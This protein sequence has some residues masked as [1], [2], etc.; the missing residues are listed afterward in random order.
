MNHSHPDLLFRQLFDEASCTFTYL[1]ADRKTGEAILI[2]TVREKVDRELKLLG[3]LNLKLVYLLETHI[4]ADHITGASLLRDK[5]GAKTVVG[6]GSN[7]ECANFSLKDGE[8]LNFGQFNLKALATPGHTHACTSFVI[9]N[10]VFTG[11]ALLIRGTGRTDFQQGS[12]QMLFHSIRE[13]LFKLPPETHVYPAHDYNGRT[14]S[15]I[16]EEQAFNPRVAVSKSFE[17]FAAIMKNLKLPDPKRIEE[18][19]PANLKCGKIA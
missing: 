10:L 8:T 1:L 17:E 7:I 4:H 14:S 19:V 16:Q 13:K 11:D 18:A 6:E 9:G 12:P 2:D 15:T 3:E 5:T